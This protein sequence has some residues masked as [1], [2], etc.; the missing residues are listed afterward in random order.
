M[1]ILQ[2]ATDPKLFAGWFRRGTFQAWFAFLAAA[3]G[4]P[5][6]DDQLATYRQ[7]TGRTD[8]PTQQA[9]EVWLIV[10]RRGGKSLMLAIIGVYVATFKTYRQH[11]QPGERATVRI[12]AADRRQARTIFRYVGGLLTRIPMLKKM[13][14]RETADGFDLTNSVTIEIGTSSMK[15]SR[16]YSFA[17]ILADEAAYWPTDEAAEPDVE[18]LRA[19]R[20]GLATIPGAMLLVASSPYAKRGTLWQAYRDHYAKNGDPI[21]VWKADTASM[22]PALDKQVIADAYADDPVAASAEY[23][24]EF[25]SDLEAYVSIEQVLGVTSS[26]VNVRPYNPDIQYAAFADAAGGSGKDSFTLAIGHRVADMIVIDLVA[27]RPPP[28][29]PEA[30]AAE[31]ADIIRSYGLREVHGDAYAAMFATEAFERNGISYYR[32]SA[33]RS[34]LYLELL[35]ILNSGRVDLLD[36]PKLANQLASLERST[37]RGRDSVDHRPGSHDDVSNA[38]AGVAYILGIRED[39]APR[40]LSGRSGVVIDEDRRARATDPARLAYLAAIE[41]MMS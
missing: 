20:P 6:T 34:K 11:L 28:F 36:I 8:P 7:F 1:N 10:G 14:E 30:V 9:R 25:R 12:M 39:M 31:F 29:S 15:S 18:V 37:G 22:N 13:I 2:A 3:F 16:G 41:G 40:P 27:E 24:A 23:G 38:V 26:S 5:M 21:L 32:S 19:V 17:A 4:L 33:V 35:P